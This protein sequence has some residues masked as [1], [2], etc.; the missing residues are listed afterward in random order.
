ML[1][2]FFNFCGKSAF[3][4]TS[5]NSNSNKRET[6]CNSSNN[7]RNSNKRKLVGFGSQGSK[8]GKTGIFLSLPGRF[9]STN[10]IWELAFCRWSISFSG[11][12]TSWNSSTRVPAD[13]FELLK[14]HSMLWIQIFFYK[15]E[16]GQ[17]KIATKCHC[18]K[19]FVE[20]QPQFSL[21]LQ[22]WI[23]RS[24]PQFF[25]RGEKQNKNAKMYE[26][27]NQDM[28]NKPKISIFR[29]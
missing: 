1:N 23:L 19:S 25:W 18:L 3:G 5:N 27:W 4:E 16:L 29:D 14:R 20:F 26:K 9:T 22:T 8:N 12:T 17:G 7:S 6:S 15:A 21:Y 28:L 2:N 10:Q 24:K 13:I 11:T